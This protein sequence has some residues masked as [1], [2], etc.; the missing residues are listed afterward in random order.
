MSSSAN[1]TRSHDESHWSL[2]RL[3]LSD[4]NRY[5]ALEHRSHLSQMVLSPGTIASIH[6]RIGHWLWS[7]PGRGSILRTLSKAAYLF[8]NRAME[9]FT[10]ISIAPRAH[11]GPGLH[12][13]H[14]GGVIV[15]EGVVI[16][17]NCNLSHG[18]TLGVSGRSDRG[19]PHIGD[20]VFIGP[21]AKAFG[22]ITVGD[23]AAIGANAVVTKSV[24]E[25]S[26]S[27]GIPARTVSFKGSFE[28]IIYDGM[29]TDPE[30][31]TSFALREQGSSRAEVEVPR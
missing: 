11:I 16:G 25:R 31:A 24:P 29:D 8:V 14:F 28:Y 7:R 19:S 9:V 23:D 21:G 12:I 20:R 18:V 4:L 2:R 10:G 27:V 1:G 30:R 15:G 26:V 13:N 22:K 5:R 3:I 17:S 6:Y